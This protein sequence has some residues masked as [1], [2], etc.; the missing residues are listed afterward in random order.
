[1][2]LVDGIAAQPLSTSPTPL[3]SFDVSPFEQRAPAALAAGLRRLL[4]RSAAAA[5]EAEGGGAG[6]GSAS[7]MHLS[8]GLQLRRLAEHA[9]RFELELA[10]A[11]GLQ[12][13]SSKG[14]DLAFPD[15]PPGGGAGHQVEVRCRGEAR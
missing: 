4:E 2:S 12:G 14:L 8:D 13:V 15:A 7:G 9:D 10:V 1:M 6:G 11:P 3:A 5:D